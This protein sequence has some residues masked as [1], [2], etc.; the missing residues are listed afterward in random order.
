MKSFAVAGEACA[1]REG[2]E[3]SP[4]PKKATKQFRESGGDESGDS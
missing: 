2:A 4:R 3:Q 1:E